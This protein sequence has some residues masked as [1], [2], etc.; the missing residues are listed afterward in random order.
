[1]P[2]DYLPASAARRL[3]SRM[4]RRIDRE[5]RKVDEAIQE[6]GIAASLATYQDGVRVDRIARTTEH[7]MVRAAQLGA[8]EHALSQANPSAAGYVHAV[9]CAGAI[10]IAGVVHEAGRG[11]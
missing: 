10:G 5:M 3:P 1:M 7:G 4:R 9:A 8:L 6:I 11:F 2:H